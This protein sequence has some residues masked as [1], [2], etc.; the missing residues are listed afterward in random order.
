MKTTRCGLLALWLCINAGAT[1]AAEVTLI[2]PGGIRDAIVKMIPD[3]ERASGHTVKATFGSG[4]GTKQQVMKGEVF[5][6]PVVQP[7]LDEVTVTGHVLN[8]SAT[9]LA[10][11]AVAVAVRKG[12]PKPDIST[13]EAVKK[14]LLAAKT[15][16]YPDGARGAAAGVSFDATMRQLGIFEEMKPKIVRV[17]GGAAAMAAIARGEVELGLTFLSEIHDPGVEVVGVL[18]REISTPTALFGFI[19]AKAG[20]PEAARALLDYLSSPA[21]ARVYR[22]MGMQPGR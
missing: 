12:M 3:F 14:M 11:V 7:P 15:V 21:A 6:V 5:D 19:H 2:A 10:T 18:P 1:G 16:S 20:S 9:P 13:A 17:Q 8:A 4:L 22:D